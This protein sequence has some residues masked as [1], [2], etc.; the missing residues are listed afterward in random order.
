MQT[1]KEPQDRKK[2]RPIRLVDSGDVDAITVYDPEN[3]IGN[4]YLGFALATTPQLRTSLGSSLVCTD[5]SLGS[6]HVS[7]TGFKQTDVGPIDLMTS[8]NGGAPFVFDS[9]Q[10]TGKHSIERSVLLTVPPGG[11]RFDVWAQFRPAG[12]PIRH[13]WAMNIFR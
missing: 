2:G 9:F 12:L 1:P 7:V 11:L 5:F 6:Y 4:Q 10:T 3:F 8:I 13:S